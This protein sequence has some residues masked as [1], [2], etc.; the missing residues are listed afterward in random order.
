MFSGEEYLLSLMIAH[1]FHTQ[2][3]S[4]GF[5]ELEEAEHS[6]CSLRKQ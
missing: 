5:E 6:Q 1:W 2:M 4:A 3:F